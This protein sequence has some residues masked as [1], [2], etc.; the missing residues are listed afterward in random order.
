[1]SWLDLDVGAEQKPSLSLM[2]QMAKHPF[3]AALGCINSEE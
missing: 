3:E 2:R 1:M